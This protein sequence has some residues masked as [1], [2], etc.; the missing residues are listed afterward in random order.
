VT[1]RSQRL[2]IVTESHPAATFIRPVG[3][4]DLACCGRLRDALLTCSAQEPPGIV[5]DLS[6]LQVTSASLL[7]VFTTVSRQVS[8]WPGTP[9]LLAS[10]TPPVASLLRRTAVSRFVAVYPHCAGAL[11]AVRAPPPRR[12]VQ[13]QL[14]G[15]AASAARARQVVDQTCRDWG[16]EALG[17]SARLIASE[18]V[19]N[20][21]RHTDCAPSLRLEWS[22][23]RFVVAVSDGDPRPP[24]LVDAMP[25]HPSGRGLRLVAHASLHWGYAPTAAGGKVVWASL[26]SGPARPPR[27]DRPT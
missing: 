9:L 19:S 25:S 18:L 13:V 22:G 12:R 11:A 17:D 2:R 10:P 3:T 21:V 8:E 7:S 24:R 16:L 20:V 6:R 14:A 26:R 4:L 15:D 1:G 5:V 23:P 27:A